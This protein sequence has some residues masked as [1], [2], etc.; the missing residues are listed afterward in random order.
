MQPVVFALVN[1]AV[2]AIALF[3]FM[4]VANSVS[5]LPLENFYPFGSSSGDDAFGPTDDGSSPRI[6]LSVPLLFFG[7]NFNILYVRTENRVRV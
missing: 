3:T 5:T 6:S 7:T 1:M 2:R 4:A